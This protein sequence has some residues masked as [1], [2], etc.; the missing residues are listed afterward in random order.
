[1][2]HKMK[3]AVF[4]RK[5]G[6]IMLGGGVLALILIVA[7]AAPLLAPYDPTAIDP[8]SQKA[9]PSALHLMGTD[10]FGRDIFSQVLYGARISLLVGAVV[11]IV[12][13]AAGIVLGLL[14]GYYKLVD[15]IVM[16]ILE[17]ISAF[18]EMLLALTL[19]CIFGNGVDKVII[20]LAI[21]GTPNV[22][23]IV[24]SQV[25]SIKESEHVESARAMGATDLRIMFKYI[26]PLCVSPL[27]IRFTTTMASAILTEASLSFLGVGVDPT[28]PTWGSI[29][30]AAKTFVISHPYMAIYPGV[31]IVVTVLSISILG[32]GL[33]DLLDPKMK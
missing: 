22:A 15:K 4:L 20:A 23:R 29:L 11:A 6:R 13:T 8:Y 1:M 12:S 24:R 17:G 3:P 31:A 7:V 30:S 16:R 27:I 18:P 25:L 10:R 28:T 21:V 33:R 5:Y 19:A 26:L 32:D 9:F 14:M 2:Q